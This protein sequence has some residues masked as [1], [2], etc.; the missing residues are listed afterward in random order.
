V[1]RPAELARRQR[2]LL[3]EWEERHGQLSQAHKN[4]FLARPEVEQLA[5]VA[6][7]V[8]SEAIRREQRLADIIQIA[9]QLIDTQWMP[10]EDH[11]EAPRDED[12]PSKEP[13]EFI[14][15]KQ[16][17]EAWMNL[18]GRPV[19]GTQFRAWFAS[20]EVRAFLGTSV[21]L[22]LIAGERVLAETGQLSLREWRR[23]AHRLDRE[24]RREQQRTLASTSLVLE[25]RVWS[26]PSVNGP[27]RS[28]LPSVQNYYD[29]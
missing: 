10:D 3:L 28:G 26:S 13:T 15:K 23:A 9:R 5:C 4:E 1:P 25:D 19:S 6:P 18:T 12:R 8:A 20:K 29:T 22:A 16:V 11:V 24:R 21:E 7:A 27:K 14:T 17:L 2:Q